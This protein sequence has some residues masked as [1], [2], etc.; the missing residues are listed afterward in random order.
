[1][2]LQKHAKLA[3]AGISS[4]LVARSSSQKVPTDPS[5]DC[6]NPNFQAI[7]TACSAGDYTKCCGVGTQ[8]C[9]GGCCDLLSV[10]VGVGTSQETCCDYSDVTYC[11]TGKA[12]RPSVICTG[13]SGLSSYNCPPG[14]TCNIHNDS[15]YVP[16]GGSSPSPKPL[17]PVPS[18]TIAP[19]LPDPTPATTRRPTP[20]SVASSDDSDATP[21]SSAKAGGGAGAG[22]G[23]SGAGTTGPVGS[24]GSGPSVSVSVL[25]VSASAS[26]SPRPSSAASDRIVSLFL[27]GCLAGIAVLAALL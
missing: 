24:P 10:C 25:T 27:G 14:S 2:L 3:L 15:C 6:S 20:T 12:P 18:S 17:P 11:G 1:M 5:F 26:S 19:T 9:A 23:G 21:S 13:S 4:L 22:T 8:C 16:E 7:Y